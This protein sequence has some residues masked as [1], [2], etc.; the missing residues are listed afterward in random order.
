MF[1]ELVR[2]QSFC[3]IEYSAASEVRPFPPARECRS[4]VPS[5]WSGFP[6]PD[7]G[8][9]AISTGLYYIIWTSGHFKFKKKS[10]VHS[11]IY[12]PVP[13]PCIKAKFYQKLLNVDFTVSIRIS[14]HTVMFTYSMYRSRYIQVLYYSM[15]R[16]QAGRL[17]D[18]SLFSWSVSDRYRTNTYA[19][20]R[21]GHFLQDGEW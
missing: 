16:F 4:S 2:S 21:R 15:S 17:I 13:Y 9:V 11:S 3:S 12:I 1:G 20:E 6:V 8:K 7:R 18:F 5:A 19:I 14:Y 10:S